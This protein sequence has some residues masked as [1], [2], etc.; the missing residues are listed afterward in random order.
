MLYINTPQLTEHQQLV[1][2]NIISMLRNGNNCC[3]TG[4]AG[5]GK[6]FTLKYILDQIEH[7]SSHPVEQW[8]LING[9]Y[10]KVEKRV[11]TSN[12]I[13]TSPTHKA[14]SVMYES[15]L[16]NSVTLASLLKKTKEVN[17]ETGEVMFDPKL[18]ESDDELFI[19]VDE[20]SMLSSNDEELLISNFKNATFLFVGDKK[21]LPSIEPRDNVLF[22]NYPSEELLINMRIGQG[23]VYYDYINDVAELGIHLPSKYADIKTAAYNSFDK[24]DTIICYR[25]ATVDTMNKFLL[26][27]FFNSELQSGVRLVSNENIDQDEITR[28]Y[29][30]YNSQLLTIEDLIPSNRVMIHDDNG[31]ERRITLD[32]YDVLTDYGMVVIPRDYDKYKDTL[33]KLEKWSKA[34]RNW[35]PFFRYKGLVNDISLGYAITAH[36]AQGSGFDHPIVHYSDIKAANQ[37]IRNACYYTAVSRARKSIRLAM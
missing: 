27:R 26:K 1:A 18:T 5:T 12:V 36:K 34:N 14:A 17:Y 28:R 32:T 23:N 9:K 30:I 13:C 6:T 8:E 22:D 21:Q 24:E 4:S 10:R 19:I 33:A 25:T 29:R 2:N 3:L 20:A 31:T 11:E 15:T 37:D 35:R 7:K 16:R